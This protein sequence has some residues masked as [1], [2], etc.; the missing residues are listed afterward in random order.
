MT[1]DGAC[2]FRAISKAVTGT[3]SN[4]RA[5]RL[6]LI[7]FMLHQENAIRFARYLFAPIYNTQEKA[8]KCLESY[9]ESSGMHRITSWGS[10]KEIVVAAT[11]FQA[12]INIFCSYGSKRSWTTV[13]PAFFNSTC[14]PKANVELYLYH[15]GKREDR[16]YDVGENTQQPDQCTCG[17]STTAHK[18]TCPLNPRNITI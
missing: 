14:M 17:S 11:L 8:L 13:G 9:I 6:A 2:L 15:R 5:V 10:D 18:H 12:N 1:G 16:H 7:N 4:H 3:Q